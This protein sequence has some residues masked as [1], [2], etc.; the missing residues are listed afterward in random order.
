MTS[1]SEKKL[2][3]LGEDFKK[4]KFKDDK[5]TEILKTQDRLID[6]LKEENDKLK[7]EYE[8]MYDAHCDLEEQLKETED[9]NVIQEEVIDKLK[10][11]LQQ[12]KEENKKL[13]NHVAVLKYQKKKQKVETDFQR[14]L[15]SLHE[16]DGGVEPQVIDFYNSR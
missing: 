14:E 8:E 2:L 12:I 11:E 13:R 3:K 15:V 4:L 1:F 5:N 6:M 7:G 9:D 10:A 16:G